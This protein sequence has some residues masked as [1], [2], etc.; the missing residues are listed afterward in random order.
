MYMSSSLPPQSPPPPPEPPITRDPHTL[1][2]KRD[3][4]APLRLQLSAHPFALLLDGERAGLYFSNMKAASASV[5]YRNNSNTYLGRWSV[6]HLVWGTTWLQVELDSFDAQ[7][8][9]LYG[10]NGAFEF[11]G[12]YKSWLETAEWY[13][14]QKRVT[15]RTN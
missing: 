7:V 6:M 2:L 13:A 3:L 4:S 8:P 11:S 10:G 14:L 9:F 12:S 5:R 1:R 15:G